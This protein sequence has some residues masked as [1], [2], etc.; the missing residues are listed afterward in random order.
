MPETETETE[1][2][3]DADG[4]E[5][6]P[7]REALLEELE[8]AIAQQMTASAVM[9]EAAEACLNAG[10]PSSPALYACLIRTARET[11]ENCKRL[12]ALKDFEPT[13]DPANVDGWGV[14]PTYYDRDDHDRTTTDDPF[15]D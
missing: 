9:T 6:P 4:D 11:T 5:P 15:R 12:T 2:A 13:V 3:T 7:D 14:I 10:V 1:A 8:A